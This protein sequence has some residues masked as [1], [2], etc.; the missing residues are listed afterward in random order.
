MSA[1]SDG[2]YLT[3]PN[4]SP[5]ACCANPGH[6]RRVR[7]IAEGLAPELPISLSSQELRE[8]GEYERTS[9]TVINAYLQP[10]V[11]GYLA[12]LARSQ[13]SVD[14]DAP[15]YVMQSNGGVMAASAASE[16]PIH[17]IE[18]GPAAGVR[19]R[20]CARRTRPI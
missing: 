11:G 7:E 5:S 12:N 2:C 3:E 19:S 16:R 18:S 4:R 10:V 17:I 15:V 1:L 8:I 14:V 20:S 6:E 9:T 13:A